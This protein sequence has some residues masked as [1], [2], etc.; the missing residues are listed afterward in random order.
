MKTI[1]LATHNR[2][3]EEEFRNRLKEFFIVKSLKDLNCFDDIAETGAT[4]KENSF[5]KADYIH[6]KYQVNV[7]AD[8]S[9]LEVEALENRPGVYSARYAGEPSD[10]TANNKKLIEELNGIE[11]RNACFRTVLTLILDEDTHHFEGEVMGTIKE[12]FGGE[13]SFGYN[14]VFIPAGFDKTF[15][16]MSLEERSQLNHR[17][18]AIDSL[19]QF[20]EENHSL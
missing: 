5:I 12:N 10:D 11:N 19:L 9:G 3:K 6:K 4:F 7:L 2:H 16:E 20:C 18:R 15:H 1:Y 17:G 8:D 14:P 13:V